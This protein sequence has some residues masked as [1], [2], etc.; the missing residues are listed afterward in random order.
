M[1]HQS[2]LYQDE[3]GVGII[4][5]EELRPLVPSAGNSNSTKKDDDSDILIIPREVQ[6]LRLENL[7]VPACYLV[8]GIVQGLSGPLL[9]VYP[10]D[11]GA[12]EAAQMTI[13]VIFQFPAAVKILYG[14]WSDSVPILGARRKPYMWMG[15]VLVSC[16]MMLLL[17]TADLT[18]EYDDDNDSTDLH[19]HTPLPPSDAPSI[20]YLSVLFFLLGVGLWLADVMGDSL[21]AEKARIEPDPIKGNL[22]SS[23]YACRFFGMMVAAPCSTV[24]YSRYGPR[25]VVMAL[26]A[27]PMIVLPLILCLREK[28]VIE[29]KSVRHRIQD[30]WNTV[31]S[32]SVWQPMAF[33]YIYNL[34][35][36]GNGAWRQ[37]LKSVLF[38]SESQ[39]NYLL[40]AS[41]VLLYLGTMAYKQW[42]LRVSWRRVYQV[43]ILLNGV[44]SGLQL[45]LICG[46]T[47]GLSP[48]L[49]A[50]GDEALAEFVTGVQFLPVT[51]M[52][53]A[54]CPE[55]SEGASY[56]LF[57]TFSNAA[58]LL[59]P[60]ISTPLLG[61]WD[62]S[63][64]TLEAG[65]L[66]G[67]FKLSVLTSLLQLSPIVV[68][69]WLPHSSQD[70][71]ELSARPKSTTGGVVFLLIVFGSLLYILVVG[72]L[73]IV[74]PGW[75]GESR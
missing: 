47:F 51:I 2:D 20:E 23:C 25:S 72:T 31:Q 8:V 15:W 26:A 64:E 39:I 66:S 5:K 48:F 44:F 53:V 33:V 69:S 30:I 34:L 14:F 54:L 63:K 7:A 73:N 42:F 18:M 46:Q 12:T 29:V 68:L 41:Y 13:P 19:R 11:L 57:T 6:L 70:L 9:N 49:F 60:T 65:E 24:L 3:G 32:R 1:I 67:F 61:I 21:V 16:T 58:I 37:F 52:M 28:K 43:C 56:A 75:S 50:L 4:N 38:F 40:I 17:G 74:A 10:L 36:V 71:H 55:G 35:Q 62:V 27:S 22:Q 59:G 45:L